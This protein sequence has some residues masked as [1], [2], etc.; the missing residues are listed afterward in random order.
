VTYD[1]SSI[2]PVCLH[3]PR[4]KTG[5]APGSNGGSA[6][7]R[8]VLHTGNTIRLNLVAGGLVYCDWYDTRR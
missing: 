5:P 7:E 4:G 8:M 2:R 6:F 1:S 3:R